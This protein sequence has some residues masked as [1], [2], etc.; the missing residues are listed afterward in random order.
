MLGERSVI[1]FHDERMLLH[2]PNVNEPF[3]PG[4]LDRRVREI[5]NGLQVQ[6]SYP[7]HP[8]RLSAVLS[9]LKEKPLTTRDGRLLIYG[10]YR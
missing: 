7:E 2:Q 4:R 3:L 5:L 9:L 10:C 8:G 6:W 1:V